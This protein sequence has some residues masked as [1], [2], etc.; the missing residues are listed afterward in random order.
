MQFFCAELVVIGFIFNFNEKN[1]NKKIMNLLKYN[2]S[3]C[4]GLAINPRGFPA[5]EPRRQD[6]LQHPHTLLMTRQMENVL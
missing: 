6:R 2:R 5:F 1:K 4:D 3:C